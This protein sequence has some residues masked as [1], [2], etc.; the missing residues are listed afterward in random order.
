MRRS[1]KFS[2]DAESHAQVALP[3]RKVEDKNAS[4]GRSRWV[5]YRGPSGE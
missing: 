4:T 5:D 1:G 2:E 3:P